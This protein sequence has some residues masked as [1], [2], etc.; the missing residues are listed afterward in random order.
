MDPADELPVESY[1]LPNN[2]P[3]GSLYHR[4]HSGDGSTGPLI[5]RDGAARAP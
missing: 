3:A 2:L 4:L 1:A 5:Y